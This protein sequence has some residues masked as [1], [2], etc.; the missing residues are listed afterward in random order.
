MAPRPLR[1][2]RALGSETGRRTDHVPLPT[3]SQEA[4]TQRFSFI[5]P[6]SPCALTLFVFV[7]SSSFPYPERPPRNATRRRPTPPA[8]PIATMLPS[9]PPPPL[10]ARTPPNV[11]N[12]RRIRHPFAVLYHTPSLSFTVVAFVSPRLR[13][14]ALSAPPIPT[15]PSLLRNAH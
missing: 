1:W 9:S 15:S 11:P 8:I 13:F 6:A 10:P 4:V 5:L 12:R 2:D 3:L 7:S 14:A